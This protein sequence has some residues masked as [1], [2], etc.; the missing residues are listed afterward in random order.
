MSTFEFSLPTP[1]RALTLIETN[2]PDVAKVLRDERNAIAKSIRV[3]L[4]DGTAPD[5]LADHVELLML[6]EYDPMVATIERLKA[7]LKALKEA[8]MLGERE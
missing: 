2:F 8:E 6:Q 7:E 1:S 3:T 4:D 5:N